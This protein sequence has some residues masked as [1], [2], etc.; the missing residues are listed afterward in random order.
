MAQTEKPQAIK[1]VQV[2]VEPGFM[3]DLKG[4]GTAISMTAGVGSWLDKNFYLGLH[5]GAF[6]GLNKGS[7]TTIPLMARAEFKFNGNRA[8]GFSLPFDVG[9]VFNSES[10]MVDV[11]PTYTLPLCDWSDLKV[12]LG[13][14]LGISTQGGQ[15]GHNLGV[16]FGWQIN[17]NNLPKRRQPTRNSGLQYTIEVGMMRQLNDHSDWKDSWVAVAGGLAITYKWNPNLAFGVVYRRENDNN[18]FALRGN[19]RL[20]DKKGSWLGSVDLGLTSMRYVQEGTSLFIAPAVGYSLR[21]SGNSYFDFKAGYR[22][23]TAHEDDWGCTSKQNG[24]FLTISWTHTT[25]F[26]QRK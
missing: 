21:A 4:G 1:T 3:V 8:A 22:I 12:G 16:R 24:L 19:Y 15:L 10:V 2:T 9:Y 25:K 14:M 7:E 20:S 17:T 26:F 23:A 11:I 13:Y 5:T 6:I 18:T